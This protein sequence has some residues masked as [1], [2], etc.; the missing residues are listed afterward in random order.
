MTTRLG[1]Q[2]L[3][4]LPNSR[5]NTPMVP[6]PQTSCVMSTSAFTQILSPAGT[7]ALPAARARIFSVNVIRGAKLNDGRREGNNGLMLREFALWAKTLRSPL[8]K[9][10]LLGRQAVLA[11]AKHV[12]IDNWVAETNC[13]GVPNVRFEIILRQD[14]L[15]PRVVEHSFAIVVREHDL[16]VSVTLRCSSPIHRNRFP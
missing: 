2:T 5:L 8:S 3:A 13:N 9:L 1:S 6:G 15:L 11:T 10:N 14:E 16:R 12:Q 7:E 4:A